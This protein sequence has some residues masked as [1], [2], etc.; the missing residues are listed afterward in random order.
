MFVRVRNV[1]QGNVLVQQG[2]VASTF[3]TRLRGLI[4]S[5][6]PAEG[7]GLLIIPC[8]GVHMFFMSYPIDVIYVNRYDQVIDVDMN[9]KPWRVGRPRKASRYVIELPAGAVARSGVQIGDQLQL[10]CK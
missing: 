10:E 1:T 8:S 7:E 9:M 4:G 2:R 6:P 5:P 3:W